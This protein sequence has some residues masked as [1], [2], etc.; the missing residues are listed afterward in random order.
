MV[1]E[2]NGVDSPQAGGAQG[3]RGKPADSRANTPANQP[4][5][6]P[7]QNVNSG[8]Q[9]TVELSAQAKALADAEA[10]LSSQQDVDTQRVNNIRQAIA[11]G[12]FQIDP[13]KVA[14]NLLNIDEA[15]E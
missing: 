6:E 11:D 14:D 1:N 7:S 12:N 4:Q 15:F 2:V 8:G 5:S 9:D 10:K 13:A 3:S